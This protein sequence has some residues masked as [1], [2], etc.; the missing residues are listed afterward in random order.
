MVD[1][2]QCAGEKAE[3]MRGKN[4]HSPSLQTVPYKKSY[5]G[6]LRASLELDRRFSG[7][8]SEESRDDAKDGT[9]T[10]L[11]SVNNLGGVSLPGI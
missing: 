5:Y 1:F 6:R 8:L 3:Y 7:R 11:C 4:D 9:L 2:V 10:R